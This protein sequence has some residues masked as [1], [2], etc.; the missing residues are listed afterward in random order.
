[1]SALLGVLAAVY[2]LSLAIAAGG[3]LLVA[4]SPSFR[5]ELI[6]DSPRV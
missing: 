6:G 4:F 5:R 3:G 2:G 1:M